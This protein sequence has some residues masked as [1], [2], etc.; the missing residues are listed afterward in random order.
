M[1]RALDVTICFFGLYDAPGQS[2][3]VIWQMHDGAELPGGSFPLGSGPTS[4]A[5]RESHAQLIREWSRE[6]PPVQLQYATNRAGLPESSIVA[7][8]V[9][10]GQVIGILAVQSYGPHAYDEDDVAL[11]QGIADQVAV[12]VAPSRRTGN[13]DSGDRPMPG[14]DVEAVLASM[15]DAL[16]V[17]DDQGRLVR[18]NQAARRL[19]SI[20]DSSVILG[21]PVDRPQADRWPLGTRALTEQL[22]PI[23][24]QLKRGAAPDEE[25]QL[26][27][28]DQADHRL[29]CKASVLLR[30]G[31]PAGG[32]V[33][34]RELAS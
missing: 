31:T 25:I 8:A 10:D 9:F 6:G 27:M 14:A 23:V 15:P 33:V 5:I 32:L 7:P 28:G 30:E 13:G 12:A 1:S 22:Q 17:L 29:S 24:D 34:L 20:V 16:L 26:A 11:V 18:L 2:V 3:E 4:R 19:L 21:H